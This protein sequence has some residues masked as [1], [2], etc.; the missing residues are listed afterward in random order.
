MLC[1]DDK[2]HEEDLSMIFDEL[3]VKTHVSKSPS[4]EDNFSSKFRCQWVADNEFPACVTCHGQTCMQTMTKQTKSSSSSFSLPH[5]KL[6]ITVSMERAPYY[7]K[8]ELK[9]I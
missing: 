1:I 2:L 9:E 7:H 4:R 8:Q 6:P 3:E 5:L